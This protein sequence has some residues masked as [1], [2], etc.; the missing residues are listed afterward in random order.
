LFLSNIFLTIFLLIY[1][2]KRISVN[3]VDNDHLDRYLTKLN[4]R[5]KYYLYLDINN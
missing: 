5:Y 1:N 3:K 4:I 2:C